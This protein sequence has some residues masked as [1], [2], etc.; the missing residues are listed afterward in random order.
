MSGTAWFRISIKSY[1]QT[2]ALRFHLRFSCIGPCHLPLRDNVSIVHKEEVC[3]IA[4]RPQNVS[5]SNLYER[6]YECAVYIR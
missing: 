1:L 2:A 3:Q 4:N 5:F 6:R